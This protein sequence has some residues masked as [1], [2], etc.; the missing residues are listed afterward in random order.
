MNPRPLACRLSHSVAA[1]A[2][3]VG[4]GAGIAAAQ[5]N[6]AIA[7]RREGSWVAVSIGVSSSDAVSSSVR[8]VHTSASSDSAVG[9]SAMAAAIWATDCVPSQRFQTLAATP[10]SQVSFAPARFGTPL[11]RSPL[12]LVDA[13]TARA[14]ERPNAR[15]PPPEI[16]DI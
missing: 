1:A 9:S 12:V 10:P 16:L 8:A 2:L 3:L 7:L 15:A 5:P 14:L 13:R 11:V 6:F 4:F